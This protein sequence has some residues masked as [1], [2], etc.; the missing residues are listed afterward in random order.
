[1]LPLATSTYPK[2]LAKRLCTCVA[3]VVYMNGHCFC[4]AFFSTNNPEVRHIARGYLRYKKN[5]IAY[6]GY[7]PPSL[8][9][10]SDDD[11]LQ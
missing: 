8:Y 7:T 5:E 4:V 9:H 2:M 10:I 1:M 6:P 11:L 3:S